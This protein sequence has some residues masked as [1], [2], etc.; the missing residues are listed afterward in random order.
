[1]AT[2]GTFDGVHRGH[3]YVFAQLVSQARQRGLEAVAVTFS[4]HPRQVLR[5]DAPDLLTLTDEKVSLLFDLALNRVEVLDFNEELASMSAYDFMRQILVNRFCVK[6]LI[7]G[8]DNRF[9]HDCKCFEDYRQFGR[10]L[11]VDVL[12]CD[13]CAAD[14]NI[15]STA[16]R[17]ALFRGDVGVAN[18]L[19]GYCY[20]LRGRVVH[21]FQNGRRLGFPTA[22]LQIDPL[23]LVPQDGVYLVRVTLDDSGAC[24][25]GMLNIGI[26]PTL[27]NGK[28]HSVE[29][30]LFDFEGDL[31]G[32]V[33]R[34]EL[35]AHL[36]PEQEFSSCQVLKNQ[37]EEDERICRSLIPT[38]V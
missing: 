10:Q 18:S 28:Q 33:L 19:L 13:E 17:Q 21:G 34:V 38:F 15:S 11:G 5:H 8:Y 12:R 29:V 2:I 7:V 4:N 36:R 20:A 16:I 35:L 37:L 31:Y 6:V 26:R 9:G 3:R 24:F 25:F 22:N 1:M 23:K 14:T 30:H 27:H 32:R